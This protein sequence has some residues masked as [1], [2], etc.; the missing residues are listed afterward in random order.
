MGGKSVCSVGGHRRDGWILQVE[1]GLL[2]RYAM[3][4]DFCVEIAFVA[5]DENEIDRAHAPQKID[6]RG[7]IGAA[8][9]MDQGKTPGR[10]DENFA[11]ACLAVKVGILAR[12]IDV[13]QLRRHYDANR[14]GLNG[15]K[16]GG[17]RG[18]VGVKSP[19]SQPLQ[20]DRS[21]EGAILSLALKAKV[22][23]NAHLDTENLITS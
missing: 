10:G 23:Q 13:E 9:F 11:R 3:D 6:E 20:I 15:Q 5:F 18:Q 7:L 21:A 2:V 14:A 17:G 19:R 22:S 8:Q 4:F 16:S 1:P 12:L